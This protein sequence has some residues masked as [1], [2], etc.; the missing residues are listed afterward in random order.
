MHA[1]IIQ[2]SSKPITKE[3][4]LD[5]YTVMDDSDFIP[6][7]ADYVDRLDP[8]EEERRLGMIAKSIG[9]SVTIDKSPDGA[10]YMSIPKEAREKYFAVRYG[11]FKKAV[12]LFTDKVDFRSFAYGEDLGQLLYGIHREYDNP[13]G[14]YVWDSDT[15]W[16]YTLDSWL[17]HKSNDEGVYIG[18]VLDY[19][20]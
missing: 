8:C 3:D 5:E 12:R 15:L 14:T 13:Y 7:V 1:T 20:F 6:Q 19:H 11:D 2:V 17:R 16:Y 9:E 4:R 10:V 18:S